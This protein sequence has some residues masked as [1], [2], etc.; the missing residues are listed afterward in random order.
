[1][2]LT[3]NSV[4]P[5][6]EPVAEAEDF[7]VA[8]ATGRAPGFDPPV[9]EV[10]PADVPV[11]WLKDTDDRF[12]GMAAAWTVKSFVLASCTRPTWPAHGFS[13]SAAMVPV[14]FVQRIFA[15]V[16]LRATGPTECGSREF[17]AG[18]VRW[19]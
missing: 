8:Y 14:A 19:S 10:S 2:E 17:M 1:M 13:R 12:A 7:T 4:H 6:A 11:I 16:E 18:P 15:G 3:S 5:D 9:P